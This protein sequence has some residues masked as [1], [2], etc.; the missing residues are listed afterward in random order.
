MSLCTPVAENQRQPPHVQRD[1]AQ[2]AVPQL[3]SF[4]FSPANDNPLPR[5]YW[6]RRGLQILLVGVLAAAWYMA[7]R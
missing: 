6:I 4:R 2:R 5:R 3:S 7:T 1:R